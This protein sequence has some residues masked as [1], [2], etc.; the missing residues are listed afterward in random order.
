MKNQEKLNLV[1]DLSLS[2]KD[3]EPNRVFSCN[4]C[5]RKF[6]SSQALGGHQNA[7]KRE[8]RL[9]HHSP[10]PLHRSLAMQ[11]HSSIIHKPTTSSVVGPPFRYKFGGFPVFGRRPPLP[12]QQAVRRLPVESGGGVKWDAGNLQLKTKECKILDLS[13][14]L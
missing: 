14:K 3:A 4:Y 1:L 8:R 9:G 7:H 2:S 10:L 12:P 6:Y 11:V 13:L 5:T